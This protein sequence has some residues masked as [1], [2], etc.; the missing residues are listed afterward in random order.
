MNKFMQFMVFIKNLITPLTK[1][2][3]IAFLERNGYDVI[4]K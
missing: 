3:A 1:A 4:K 2:A